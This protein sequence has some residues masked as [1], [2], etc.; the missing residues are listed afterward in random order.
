MKTN[1]NAV[2][3]PSDLN[4]L[5]LNFFDSGIALRNVNAGKKI[6]SDLCK[7]LKSIEKD[8]G[9]N[10]NEKEVFEDYFINKCVDD[11]TLQTGITLYNWQ[12]QIVQHAFYVAHNV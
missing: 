1:F 9:L 11:Y 2:T 10:I 8:E 12:R 4:T 6:N 3:C 5:I 7:H